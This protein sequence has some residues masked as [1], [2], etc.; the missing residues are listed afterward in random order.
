MTTDL[1]VP[2]QIYK[3]DSNR[4]VFGLYY[5]P[6]VTYFGCD[7]LPYAI[8]A[9]VIITLFVTMPTITLVLYPFQFFQKF[10]SLFPLNWHF[11]NA[12][13]DSFQG[14]YK[15]GTE[16]GT[17]DCRWFSALMLLIRLLGFIIYGM[18]LSI[19]FFVY[20]LI[21]L[22]IFL[23]AMV[24][25]QPFKTTIKYPSTDS[26]FF[27]LISLSYV[28]ALGGEIASTEKYFYSTTMTAVIFSS[29]VPITYITFLISSWLFS[30]RRWF[31]ML[32]KIPRY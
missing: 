21:V 32:I 6:S 16:P 3:P 31:N 24:N 5:S 22:I 18:T 12:F 11:L 28:A 27:I 30:R 4:S 1:L 9:I 8:L 26:I 10:L 29:F 15:D 14:C 19:M 7:H 2:T 17:F 13:V 23:I 20:A 25:I